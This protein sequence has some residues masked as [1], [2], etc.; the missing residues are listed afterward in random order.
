M[1]EVTPT[2]RPEPQTVLRAGEAGRPAFGACP[3]IL[4]CDYSDPG[5]VTRIVSMFP[6]T[7]NCHL[8]PW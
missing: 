3:A 1:A 2:S 7:V 4:F 8:L 6:A 5:A